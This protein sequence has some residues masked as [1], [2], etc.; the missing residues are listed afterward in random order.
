MPRTDFLELDTLRLAGRRVRRL[1]VADTFLPTLWGSGS[2]HYQVI[3]GALPP[4]A[5]VVDC[6]MAPGRFELTLESRDFAPI[7]PGGPVPE[8]DITLR[9]ITPR[10]AAEDR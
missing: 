4:D 2:R 1:A 9:D 5:R 3:A 8:H 10:A 6:R 7:A